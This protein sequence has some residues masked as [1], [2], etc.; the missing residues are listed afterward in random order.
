M[1]LLINGESK[2]RGDSSVSIKDLL[3]E[4]N[5]E[6]PE[7]VSVQLN[8]AFVDQ[9]EYDSVLL[10]NNDEIDFLYFMGGGK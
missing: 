7:M 5:V 4:L 6:T 1:N 3:K 9:K 8:G 10:K 2:T